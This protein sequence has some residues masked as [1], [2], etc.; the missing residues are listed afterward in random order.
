VPVGGLTPGCTDVNACNYDPAA[1]TDDG[2]CT[3]ATTWYQDFDGDGRG[4]PAVSQQNCNQP[5]GYVATANDCND[6]NPAVYIGATEVC[7]GIDNDCDGQIDEGV[8]VTLYNDNDGDGYGAGSPFQGCAGTP[9]T[10][11]ANGDC[12]NSNPNIFPGASEI[13]DGVDN[14]CDGQVDEGLLIT[15]YTDA[16]GDGYGAGNSFLTCPGTP[17]VAAQGGDCNDN[18]NSVYPGATEICDG[19]D[20]DCDGQMDEGLLVTVYTDGDGD[21]Y[22]AGLA[23][24]VC[25]VMPGFV[26]NNTDCDD[27][28]NTIYPGA[29]GT[30]EGI[31][32]NCNGTIDPTEELAATCEGDFDNNGEINVGDLLILL[33]EFGCQNGCISDMNNDGHIDTAD[34]LEFFTVYGQIC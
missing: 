29:A 18:D 17:G 1:Q 31:D 25:I 20:N 8:L 34:M 7:D 6:N 13:C 21:G 28:N 26:Q 30:A 14:D 24:Q 10:S 2:S 16:D 33:G 11:Q 3:Y 5:V 12:N 15:V 27:G 9:G 22:G 19:I 23:L 4:N 32:N